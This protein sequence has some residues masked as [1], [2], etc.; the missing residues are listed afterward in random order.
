MKRIIQTAAAIAMFACPAVAGPD[1]TTKALMAERVSMLDWGIYRIT[2]HL[3]DTLNDTLG[4][5][6]QRHN[7]Y[8]YYDFDR[9][10]I[11]IYGYAV[12]AQQVENTL[13]DIEEYSRTICKTIVGEIRSSAGIEPSTGKHVMGDDMTSLYA[14]YFTHYGYS[15]EQT[16]KVDLNVL[17]KK[18]EIQFLVHGNKCGGALMSNKVSFEE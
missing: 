5:N 15:N 10:V 8:A 14:G 7:G 12:L 17:D 1:D 3:T 6:I 18:I 16:R 13:D 2:Q 4:D 9:D 11:I